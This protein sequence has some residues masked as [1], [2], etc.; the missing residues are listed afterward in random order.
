M[1]DAPG[2]WQTVRTALRG[3]TA[4][5][6]ELPLR[7]A[8]VL[9]AIPMVL[10]M[11]MESVFAVV[12]IAYVSRL[13][14]EQAATVGITESLMSLVYT[15]AVGLGIG[16]T[17]MV[18][19]RI[20]EGDREQAAHTAA[21]AILLGSGVAVLI[22]VLGAL[23][24]ERIL[25]LMGAESGLIEVGRNYATIMMGG[26]A[27]VLLLFLLNAVFRGTGDA[28]LAMRMLWLANGIN[29]VLD[30]CLIFG[31]G[32]FPE[33]GV[34]GAAVAT[35]VG[36]GTAVLVQLYV[37][38][39][40]T[41]RIR[42]R[43]HHFRLDLPILARLVRLSGT[44]TFQTFISTASW[45][46]L[47]RILAGFGSEALA[48]YTIGIR[49]ILFAILPAWGVANAAATLVG[50][51]LGA[52]KPDRAE[53][54]VWMAARFNVALLGSLGVIFIVGAGPIIGLF[55][56]DELTQTYAVDTLRIVSAGFFFYAVGM[57]VTNSFNG[58]G[59]TW[60]PTWIN[61]LCFWLLE[62]PLAFFLAYGV[63]LGPRGVW[64]AI[65][66]A[67]STLAVVSAAI[68]R[69]GGW[70]TKVV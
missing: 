20:G 67:F 33:L 41:N 19:R 38:M 18:S 50:Q 17:A 11:V 66:V 57:V 70:K 28:H 32:P 9:L 12:D 45:I 36:R 5:L 43:L 64:L 15:A 26:N 7:R 51:S 35:N 16:A 34:T 48:G 46:G 29:L 65:T 59:D 24:A 8:I 62:I 55:G 21:Q 30:P 27:T 31:L 14:D 69:R 68:F 49:I 13:G 44:G 61:I 53:R 4:D 37:L 42:V 25:L 58:A 6:T 54:A 47:I 56:G 39:R 52:G 23:N 3:S 10:E 63:G 60:T 2:F 40:G 1:S 22:G